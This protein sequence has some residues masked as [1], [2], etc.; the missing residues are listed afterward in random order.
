MS[1]EKD[2]N[3]NEESFSSPLKLKRQK[4]EAYFERLW[5]V[6][7]EQFNPETNCMGRLR[8]ERTLDLV[9]NYLSPE[10][11]L[12]SDLGCGFGIFAKHLR[13]KGAKVDAVDI[14]KNALDHVA[15]EE[16]ITP[17]QQYVPY[18]HLEDDHYDLV[19]STELI[20]FL[21]REDYRIYFSELARLVKK[22]GHVVCSTPI[23]IYSEDALQRFASLVETEFNVEKW[24][25]SY[26]YLW[27]KFHALLHAPTS[28]VKAASDQRFRKEQIEKRKGFNKRWFQANSSRAAS[29][30]WTPLKWLFQPI[31]SLVRNNKKFLTSLESLSRFIWQNQAISHAIFIGKRR[32]LVQPPPDDEIPIERKAKKII[33]E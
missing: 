2:S 32:P 11:K 20:A 16:N 21:P 10:T 8:V 13:D 25:F 6:D 23:D 15:N 30:I 29:F 7:K 4:A 5:L 3:A 12:V 28:F 33:W 17:L 27:I 19:L 31:L 9:H 18:T 24:I 1:N 26:H 14:A 22:E